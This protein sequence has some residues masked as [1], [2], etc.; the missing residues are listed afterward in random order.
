MMDTKII[1]AAIEQEIKIARLRED[2]ARNAYMTIHDLAKRWKCSVKT[3][4]QARVPATHIGGTSLHRFHPL[5]VLAH[6]QRERIRD[7]VTREHLDAL[8]EF[9]PMAGDEVIDDLYD[10]LALIVG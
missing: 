10:T 2:M 4:R 7:Q 1:D 5:D 9:K 3:A 6:E 8:A